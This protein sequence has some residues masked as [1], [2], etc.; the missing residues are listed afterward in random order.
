MWKCVLLLAG[1]IATGCLLPF[2]RTLTGWAPRPEDGV[3][4]E[5]PSDRSTINSMGNLCVPR[6]GPGSRSRTCFVADGVGFQVQSPH[7]SQCKVTGATCPIVFEVYF[8]GADSLCP[9]TKPIQSC[10]SVGTGTA[11]NWYLSCG[12]PVTATLEEAGRSETIQGQADYSQFM[13]GG[14]L[15]FP[16]NR[17]YDPNARYRLAING[18]SI[19]GQAL[20]VPP[21]DFEPFRETAVDM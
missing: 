14:M 3:P 2:P 15:R 1:L 8:E 18:V 11:C 5:S 13:K 10:P 12:S 20:K 6:G 19:H 4:F 7:V 16:F 21:I 9:T 17:P